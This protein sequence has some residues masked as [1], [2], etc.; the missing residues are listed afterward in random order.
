MLEDEILGDEC[1]GQVWR[2][3]QFIDAYKIIGGIATQV[4]PRRQHIDI[5]ICEIQNVLVKLLRHMQDAQLMHGTPRIIQHLQFDYNAAFMRRTKPSFPTI[6]VQK[7]HGVQHD[8]ISVPDPS[9]L[10]YIYT[11]HDET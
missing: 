11:L 9:V 10:R 7:R 3:R 2:A 6:L 1:T 4:S 5:L 8:L